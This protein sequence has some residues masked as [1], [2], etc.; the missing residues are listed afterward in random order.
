MKSLKIAILYGGI[1]SEREISLKSGANVES[2]LR[3]SGHNTT[4]IDTKNIHDIK[5]LTTE[6][7]DIVY[8]ALHGKGGEDGTIQGF[9]ET[10]NLPYTGSGVNASSLSMNKAK[11]KIIYDKFGVSNSPYFIVSKFNSFNEKN[12]AKTGKNVVIKAANEGSSIGLYFANNIEDIKKCINKA[13][14]IDNE[15]VVEKNIDG[16]EFTVAVLDFPKSEINKYNKQIPFD[17]D[18]GALSVIEIIPKNDFYDF[19]S[20]YDKGGSKHICPAPIDNKLTLKLQTLALKAHK[21]L[22]CK[23]FSRTDFRISEENIPYALETNTIP[24]MTRTSLLPDAANSLGIDF[25]NLCNL[26]LKR[27]LEINNLQNLI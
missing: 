20:K 22:G 16:R 8:N 1:S 23:G 27:E 5:K 25:D 18:S 10:L 15:V 11:T 14:Q 3:S 19:S 12:L 7:F 24:G 21:S 13:L 2:S 4:L 9:L 26:I 17:E 6:K